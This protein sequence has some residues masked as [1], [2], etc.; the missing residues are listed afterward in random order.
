MIAIAALLGMILAGL[1][2]GMLVYLYIAK[3]GG[4]LKLISEILLLIILPIA[5]FIESNDACQEHPIE[6]DSYPT[7]VTLYLLPLICYFISAYF[8]KNLSPFVLALLP[9][10]IVMGLAYSLLLQIHFGANILLVLFP[11]IGLP[12]IAP[13]VGFL[14]LLKEF[15]VLHKYQQE[16][17]SRQSYSSPV[18]AS[19]SNLFLLPFWQKTPIALL[20]CAPVLALM[21]FILTLFGQAPDSMISMFTESCGFLLSNHSGCHC[22][23]DHYLC[24]IAANGSTK[25]VKPVRLGLRQ[26]EKILVNRQLLIANAFENWMEEKV[27]RIHKLVRNTYD[28]MG[29]QVNKWS[30]KKRFANV[31]YIL[32]KPLEWFFLL[33]LYCF[34]KKPENRIAIQYLPKKMYESFK[35]NHHGTQKSEN[36]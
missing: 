9:V 13:L 22:G 2:I 18:I 4:V 12:L 25:L 21:Q 28:S 33:W 15:I 34:D 26:N 7:A 30:K 27:P 36:N 17:I 11:V 19:I 5:G 31:L 6:L 24:S 1:V 16:Q 23:G 8:K 10:G 35:T 32:M 20:L 3:N 14:F 29:I